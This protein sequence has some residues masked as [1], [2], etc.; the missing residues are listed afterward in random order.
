MSWVLMTCN[1]RFGF[2]ESLQSIGQKALKRW[3][4][5]PPSAN[6]TILYSGKSSKEMGFSVKNVSVEFLK[7]QAVKSALLK[8]SKDSVVRLTRHQSKI[9]RQVDLNDLVIQ[10]EL[11]VKRHGLG[12]NP[13][14]KTNKEKRKEIS[15]IM[16]ER[17]FIIP[18]N[19]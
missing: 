17:I 18:K 8:N 15:K 6:G 14:N 13:C 4:G 5:L 1:F 3:A 9:S 19:L 10:S 7:L 11:D 2:V 12:Y 16:F